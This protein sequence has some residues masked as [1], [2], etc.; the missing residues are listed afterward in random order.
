LVAAGTTAAIAA[1]A[2]TAI[3]Q[4]SDGPPTGTFSFDVAIAH[5]K[6]SSNLNP[7]R[8]SKNQGP[9]IAEVAAANANLLIAGKKVGRGYH[10]EVVTFRP[11]KK[12]YRGGAVF[13]QTNAYDFGSGTVLFMSCL[14]REVPEPN[15][16][17]VV[18]GTGRYAGARG[19]AVEQ[20]PPVKETKKVTVI[21]VKVTFTP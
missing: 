17:A 12:R 4:G 15:L 8:G 9:V 20:F 6:S 1:G 2:G 18:G 5:A 21:R 16:C 14:A 7:A 10:A 19:A 13:T 3:G 11:H